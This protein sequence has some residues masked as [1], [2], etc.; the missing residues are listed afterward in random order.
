M[1]VHRL[2]ALLLLILLLASCSSDDGSAISDPGR[3]NDGS[4]QSVLNQARTAHSV[5]AVAVVL[6]EGDSIVEI[7]VSGTRVIGGQEPVTTSDQWHLGS[8]S[9]SITST[10]AA[11][12]IERGLLDWDTTVANVI[13]TDIPD[14]R[15]EY[16]DVRIEDLMAHTGGL[17]VDITRSD[18]LLA[19][20]YN[21][22]SPMPMNERRL[23]WSADMLR[24]PPE[25]PVGRHQYSNANY[26]VLGAIIEKVTGELWEDLLTR[27]LFAP[28]D[29]SNSGFGAPGMAAMRTQP[30]GHVEQGGS[31]RA[32]DPGD[33]EAESALAI[34]PAGTIHTTLRDFTGY[35][36]AH[37][38]GE[39]GEDGL[40]TAAMFAR[41][42]APQPGTDYGGGWV[43]DNNGW[44]GSRSFWHNGSN[45]RWFAH[46][47]IAPDRNA[48][49]LV[50][51][52]AGSRAVVEDL[53]GVMIQRYEAGR[54]P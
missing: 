33:D 35:M 1:T 16:H 11:I 54:N 20:D 47:V 29:M 12:Y 6:I 10:L 3:P 41:L 23:N 13:L 2:P 40:L 46:T 49:V 18:A 42:H 30:W 48:A 19:G 51:S 9:K 27:E 53:I 32:I 7:G 14:M 44:A 45:G 31:W 15:S 37:L 25:T 24:L 28:L 17:P 34:G 39:R 4:L 50:A 43:S 8:I 21:D 22:D 5:P 38:A 26:I 36:A 52:N